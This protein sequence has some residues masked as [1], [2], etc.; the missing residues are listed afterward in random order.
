MHNILLDISD[1]ILGQCCPPQAEALSTY[2]VKELDLNLDAGNNRT[3]ASTIY[4]PS[5]MFSS[6]NLTSFRLTFAAGWKIPET[7]C[8]PNPRYVE[9]DPFR[10]E[11]ENSIQRLLDGCSRLEN[12]I[13]TVKMY[14][15]LDEE[16]KTLR[17]SSSSLKLLVVSWD[18]TETPEM[19][20]DLKS[21]SL[22]RLT[23]SLKGG[24]KLKV[25]TP[26]LEFLSLSGD[27]LELNMIQGVDS[28][29]EA[30]INAEY[31]SQ[32]ED[33]ED[34]Y[35]RSQ[36]ATKFFHAMQNLRLLTLSETIMKALYVSKM[37]MPTFQHLKMIKFIP[38][39]C[40]DFPRNW[41]IKVFIKLF[42]SCPNLEILSFDQLVKNFFSEDVPLGTIFPLRFVQHIKQMEIRSFNGRVLEYKVLKHFLNN[43]TSLQI[44]SLKKFQNENL[45]KQT[46]KPKERKQILS[47]H[48]CSEQCEV[49]FR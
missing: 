17:M 6:E 39:Y 42:A 14:Y 8:L 7:V 43:G 31:L 40:D 1:G 20:V 44:V 15:E 21:D 38:F 13:L 4:I 11:D 30:V 36:K 2:K 24:H 34:L 16:V 35:S 47:I 26:N 18:V 49:L 46:W 41:M 29:H 48:K 3:E 9:F 19:N 12:F 27:V 32:W 23:L 10:F 33:M 22:Q 37:P 25:D 28:I 5:D 45:K